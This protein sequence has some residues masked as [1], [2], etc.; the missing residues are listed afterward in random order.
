[1]LIILWKGLTGNNPN[2]YSLIKWGPAAQAASVPWENTVLLTGF[3]NTDTRSEEQSSSTLL[4]PKYL[5]MRTF[6]PFQ[7]VFRW[8]V[9]A[10]QSRDLTSVTHRAVLMGIRPPRVVF[11]AVLH[12]HPRVSVAPSSVD[13][14]SSVSPSRSMSHAN[15][16]PF[17][18]QRHRLIYLYWFKRASYT[19]LAFGLYSKCRLES[20]NK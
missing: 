5:I 11:S 1:M 13:P 4:L 2:C 8:S 10:G 15:F 20:R 18:A 6:V 7:I 14:S 16:G 9:L 12:S 17:I 3:A 19:P